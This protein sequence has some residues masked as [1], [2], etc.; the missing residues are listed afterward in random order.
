MPSALPVPDLD[1]LDLTIRMRNL[2]C[3]VIPMNGYKDQPTDVK[4]HDTRT[5]PKD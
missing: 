2:Y 5:V 3:P 1:R 4:F